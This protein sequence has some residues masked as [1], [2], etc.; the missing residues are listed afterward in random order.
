MVTLVFF[1]KL[2]CQKE[3]SLFFVGAGKEVTFGLVLEKWK[4]FLLLPLNE[5][6]IIFCD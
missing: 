3:R 5:F 2:F 6:G 1:F 4:R